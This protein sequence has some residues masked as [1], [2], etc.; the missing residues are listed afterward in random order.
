LNKALITCN[1]IT[2]D[3]FKMSEELRN[4]LRRLAE[5]GSGI[6][7]IRI[8]FKLDQPSGNGAK[9]EECLEDPM[10]EE[11]A[12]SILQSASGSGA[13]GELRLE[14]HG[15]ADS[16]KDDTYNENLAWKRVR[17][18]AKTLGD[19]NPKII[20]EKSFSHGKKHAIYELGDK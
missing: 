13:S 19:R 12:Y 2:I 14:L 8:H 17:W 10:E 20:F 3:A 11:M 18:I 1:A 5:K 16:L 9:P 7:E 4:R 15:Y 6:P